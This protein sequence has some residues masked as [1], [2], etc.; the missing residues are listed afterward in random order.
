MK[1]KHIYTERKA[2]M[3][4]EVSHKKSEAKVTEKRGDNE[5][6]DAFWDRKGYQK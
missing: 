6:H 4:V 5:A 3:K 2:K 1:G